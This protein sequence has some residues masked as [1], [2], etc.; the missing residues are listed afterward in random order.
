MRQ[1][2]IVSYE[3]IGKD[4]RTYCSSFIYG[5]DGD[6]DNG[7]LATD[8]IDMANEHAEASYKKVYELHNVCIKTIIPIDMGIK[9]HS[10]KQE[11]EGDE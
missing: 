9:E 6:L 4:F 2:F 1:H 7:E 3:F 10:D 11:N 5:F 8:I